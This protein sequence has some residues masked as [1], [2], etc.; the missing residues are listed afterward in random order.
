MFACA[1]VRRVALALALAVGIAAAVAVT[2]GSVV[3]AQPAAP[4]LANSPKKIRRNVSGS[5]REVV[6]DVPIPAPVGTDG[7]PQR[8]AAEHASQLAA[9]FDSRVAADFPVDRVAARGRGSTVRVTQVV[10]S[11]PVYGAQVAMALTADGR[12]LSATGALAENVRGTF[13]AVA[14]TERARQRA[15]AQAA[16]LAR[17]TPDAVRVRS[18]SPTWYD[19]GLSGS[20][21]NEHAARPA[22]QFE[23]VVG[24][25]LWRVFVAAETPETVLDAWQ[26]EENLERVICDA[27]ST[28]DEARLDIPCGGVGSY[29]VVRAEGQS[30]VA[31]DDDANK[32][33]DWFGATEQF[34]HRYTDLGALTDFIGVDAKDGRGKAL[35]ADVRVCPFTCPYANAY[36]AADQGIVFGSAVLGLD[37]VAHELTHGVT[38]KTSGLD[39]LNES[40]AINES[41][42]D[43]FG[44][45]T[46]LTTKDAPHKA[47]DRWK[48]GAGTPAGVIRD[49]RS[50][51]TT[52][53]PETYR[54]PG[55]AP[56]TYSDGNRV[57]DFGGV[58]TNSGVGNRLAYLITDGDNA[59][60]RGVRRAAA[61]NTVRG[62]GIAKAAALYWGVQTRLYRSADYQALGSAL[63]TVCRDDVADAVADL[64]AADCEQVRA[65]VA[66]VQI[67]LLQD[68]S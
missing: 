24:D 13:P 36:W 4:S 31:S 18:E 7:D 21:R 15:V 10:D 27:D 12:L 62:I 8:V 43:V 66:A 61:A 37:V 55:W 46:A 20:G 53:Q 54:G 63:L 39:Y 44:E 40:G 41:L 3:L 17:V 49:M 34:Y 26:S 38:E 5:V 64:T 25:D 42:S 59:A 47:A 58:H 32:A 33:Y 48:I 9:L 50:P 2:P 30:P 11:V 14:P 22:Y 19:P 52:G 35:R 16:D 57:P 45:F 56:A 28:G 68:K 60:D 65:A 29:P 23:L 51:R 6:P 67:P 1:R